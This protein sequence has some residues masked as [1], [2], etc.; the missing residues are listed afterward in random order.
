[1]I[2]STAFVDFPRTEQT[3]QGLRVTVPVALRVLG[4]DA[5]GALLEPGALDFADDAQH[6]LLKTAL[7]ASDAVSTGGQEIGDPTELA[8]VHL[9]HKYTVDETEYR[10]YHPR[11]AELAFDADR[12]LMSTLHCLDGA[13]WTCCLPAAHSL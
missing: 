10:R 11:L 7:L 13:R 4:T 6:W 1:M 3:E 12:K 5:D 2:D 8:L 9:G